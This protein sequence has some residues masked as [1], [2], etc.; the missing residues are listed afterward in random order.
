MVIKK[1]LAINPEKTK[2]LGKKVAKELRGGEIIGLVGSLGGG[3]TTFA[4]GMAR[5]LGIKKEITSPTFVLWRLYKVP[6]RKKIKY[7]CH[8]DLYRIQKL[9]DIINLGMEEYWRRKDVVCLIEWAEKILPYLKNKNRYLV[10]FDIINPTTREIII[11]KI[12]RA[13]KNYGVKR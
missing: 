3:K 8:I 11:K 13:K 5:G 10:K 7:L 12:K 2:N 4:K 9:K 1:Y 6:G